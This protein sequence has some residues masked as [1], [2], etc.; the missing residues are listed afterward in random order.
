M[1][2]HSVDLFL[3]HSGRLATPY[4]VLF[5]SSRTAH[6][7]TVIPAPYSALPCTPCTACLRSTH[8]LPTQ[9]SPRSSSLYPLYISPTR[10]PLLSVVV[11]TRT[12][13][14]EHGTKRKKE[15]GRVILLVSSPKLVRSPE[16][17]TALTPPRRKPISSPKAKP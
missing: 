17:L 1:L 7:P 14:G 11:V 5:F 2:P 16:A 3:P 4:S 10:F 12:V 8:L 6:A 15:G 9:S 13:R